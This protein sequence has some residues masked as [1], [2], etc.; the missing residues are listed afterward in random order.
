MVPVLPVTDG[1]LRGRPR[2]TE[3]KMAGDVRLHEDESGETHS[4][5]EAA[6]HKP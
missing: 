4:H 1:D 6:E 5:S 3:L 2:V